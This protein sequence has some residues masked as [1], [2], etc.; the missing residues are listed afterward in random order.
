[1][2]ERSNIYQQKITT[3]AEKKYE[4]DPEAGHRITK[5]KQV[6][7]IRMF[8]QIPNGVMGK[9]T[10]FD[11]RRALLSLHEWGWTSFHSLE[12]TTTGKRVAPEQ[13]ERQYHKGVATR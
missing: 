6:E 3:Y 1:M 12:R 7:D 9:H 11:D 2:R 5:E 4:G 10:R 13:M 8:L